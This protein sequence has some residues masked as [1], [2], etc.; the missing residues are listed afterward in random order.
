M[1]DRFGAA[2][3]LQRYL[4]Q[5]WGDRL[6]R[7]RP[8]FRS[9]VSDDHSPY[10]YSVAFGRDENE[11]RLLLEAQADSPSLSSNQLAAQ[12]LTTK[13]AQDWGLCT[14]RLDAVSDLFLPSEPQGVF[15][16]WHAI[17]IGSSARPLFKVYFNPRVQGPERAHELV[18]L[19]LERLG[20]DAARGYLRAIASSREPGRDE[21]HY[22]SLDLGAATEARVKIYFRHHGITA[23]ELERT[24]ELA[25]SHQ[26]GDITGY[27]AQLLG[28][29]GPFA[30]KPVS[31][32]FAFIAGAREPTSVTFHLPIAAYAQQDAHVVDS[33]AGFMGKHGLDATAY[34]ALMSRFSSRP[35]ANGTGTQSYVS[36]RRD[37]T[38]PRLT[39]YLS[40]EV[41]ER[42]TYE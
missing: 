19:A 41:Y 40:P 25:P 22:I 4:F 5:T 11:L 42:N 13:I 28:H 23:A 38:G 10:E 8:D 24:F 20:F 33:V 37:P 7:P 18:D 32:C 12:A 6:I 31:S 15:S 1:T 26:P 21:P 16:Y 36:F 39:V 34:R 27:C 2:L 35:L 17:V 9:E 3:C 29:G 30:K 14:A